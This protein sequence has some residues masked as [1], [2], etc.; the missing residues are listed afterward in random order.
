MKFYL[1]LKKAITTGLLRVLA[2]EMN[3]IDLTYCNSSLFR[4]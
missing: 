3:I 4:K 1:V 2:Y